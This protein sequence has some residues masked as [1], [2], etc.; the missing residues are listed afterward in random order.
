MID[1]CHRLTFV[2]PPTHSIR[3]SFDRTTDRPYVYDYNTI[4]C[5][6]HVIW[7][8]H[9]YPMDTQYNHHHATSLNRKQKATA[10]RAVKILLQTVITHNPTHIVHMYNVHACTTTRS[11]RLMW[12]ILMLFF[13]FLIQKKWIL[14]FCY[15]PHLLINR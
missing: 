5:T 10:V 8:L 14:Y 15:F 12:I 6:T 2:V 9:S 4:E 7:T 11:Y 13:V 3:S 1:I